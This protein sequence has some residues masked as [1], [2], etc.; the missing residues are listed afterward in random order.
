MTGST[1]IC[2]PTSFD[3]SVGAAPG[4]QA[5]Y[6]KVSSATTQGGKVRKATEMPFNL[7]LEAAPL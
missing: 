4:A 2:I 7:I 5:G 6:P 3:H 1:I